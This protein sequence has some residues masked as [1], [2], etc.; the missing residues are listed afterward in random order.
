ML[1]AAKKTFGVA[2]SSAFSAMVCGSP[3][4]D[5]TPLMQQLEEPQMN[6]LTKAAAAALIVVGSTLVLAQA[7]APNPA[8]ATNPTGDPRPLTPGGADNPSMKDQKSAP[9]N[10][11]PQASP[12]E[13]TGS[14]PMGPPGN[15]TPAPGATKDTKD[16]NKKSPN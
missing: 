5:F 1:V 6:K 9:T 12:K 4:S 7:P 2:Q 16:V 8:E 11:T 15:E 14:R 13:G 10:P 3:G